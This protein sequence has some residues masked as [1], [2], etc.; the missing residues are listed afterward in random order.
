M[1]NLSKVVLVLMSFFLSFE[2]SCDSINRRETGGQPK[3][4]KREK[5]LCLSIS[6]IIQSLSISVHF[7][8]ILIRHFSVPFYILFSLN[9]SLWMKLIF[10]KKNFLEIGLKILVVNLATTTTTSRFSPFQLHLTLIV[11]IVQEKENCF[12]QNYNGLAYLK[13]V[14]WGLM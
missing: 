12:Y 13:V 7:F 4:K 2:L 10:T 9:F 1:G 3:Q 11:W 5:L 6:P 14:R 8:C